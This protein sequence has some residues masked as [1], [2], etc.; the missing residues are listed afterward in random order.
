MKTIYTVCFILALNST[1]LAQ[2]EMNKVSQ[3]MISSMC[4]GLMSN[5][6]TEKA[7]F[8]YDPT[9]N[10]FL[11]TTDVYEITYDGLEN[12]PSKFETEEDGIPFMLTTKLE[13]PGLEFKTSADNGD[14]FQFNCEVSCNNKKLTIPV[15][16]TF[17]YAPVI[18][19][20]NLDGAPIHSFR[21]D[22]S[23]S[24]KPSDLDLALSH[25][26]NQIV[27]K[28]QDTIMNTTER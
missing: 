13:I 26:C 19:E 15:T 22:F 14:I 21:L 17:F 24:F 16:F 2:G 10:Q 8:Q 18:A 7:V 27:V 6:D 9:N 1:L 23:F 20:S 11:M 5:N 28:A 4:G 12:D 3:I 25:D